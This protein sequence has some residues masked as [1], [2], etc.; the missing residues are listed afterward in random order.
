MKSRETTFEERLKTVKYVIENNMNYKDVA[1]KYAV[2]YA[3]VY[4]WTR[5]YLDKGPE[6]LKY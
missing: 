1:D 6:A 2:T 4:K 5:T 3:L